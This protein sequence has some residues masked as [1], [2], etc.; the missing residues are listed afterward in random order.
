MYAVEN[1]TH[2]SCAAYVSCKSTAAT[3]VQTQI[4]KRTTLKPTAAKEFIAPTWC[5]HA[6]SP[7]GKETFTWVE[8]KHYPM[9]S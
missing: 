9:Q 1:P 4:G 6:N 3:H 7:L 5:L 8:L 2:N